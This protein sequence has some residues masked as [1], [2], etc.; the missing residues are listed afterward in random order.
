VKEYGKDSYYRGS[1]KDDN[2]YMLASAQ[3]V[4]AMKPLLA[5]EKQ[6]RTHDPMSKF[7]LFIPISPSLPK[8]LGYL[9]VHQI[10]KVPF[11]LSLYLSLSVCRYAYI[12]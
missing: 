3:A 11:S 4:D 6:P 2:T 1:F 9:P 8:H 10:N 7:P 5:S 12:P